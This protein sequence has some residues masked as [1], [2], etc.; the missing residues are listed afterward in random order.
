QVSALLAAVITTGL[1][2]GV[3]GVYSHTIMRGLKKTDDR[4]F[5]VAFQAMDRAIINPLFM[6]AFL[7]ALLFSWLAVVLYLRGDDHSVVPWVVVAAALY[8]LVVIITFAVHLPL[9]D[10]IKSAGNPDQIV[11]LAAVR[12]KFHETRWMA[13]NIVRAV[14]STAAFACLAWALVLHG[15]MTSTADSNARPAA[16]AVAAPSPLPAPTSHGR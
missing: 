12:A 6:L 11:D 13:W 1:M 8:L 4:T 5:V 3:F 7:G 2:A 10:S 9:N 15:R 16:I 14:A